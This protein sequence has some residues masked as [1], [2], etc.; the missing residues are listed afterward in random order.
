MISMMSD[1][2]L[3]FELIGTVAFAISGASVG[4]RSCSDLFGVLALGIVT[5][6]GGGVIR[7]LVLGVIPPSGFT[8]PIYVITAAVS[9]A[10]VFAVAYL[11]SRHPSNLNVENW[12]QL[13]LVM[14]SIGLGIFTVVG[15]H[16]AISRYGTGNGFLCVFSGLVTG[17]GGGLLRDMMVDR[18]PDIFRKH[19]YAVASIIGAEVCL[20]LCRLNLASF[21]IAAGAAVIVVVRVLAAHFQWNLPRIEQ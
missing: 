11:K 16:S 6:T 17:V 10:I 4:L 9:S 18:L 1:Y 2:I 5:A 12:K 19:V 21:S 20:I 3:I 13:L 7:D 14:D 15:V 8:D